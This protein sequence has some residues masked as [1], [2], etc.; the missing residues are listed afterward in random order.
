MFKKSASE[1][2]GTISIL[3][4]LFA[5]LAWALSVFLPPGV[6]WHTAFRPAAL[7]LLEGQSPY[8]VKGYLNAPWA[9]IPL[10]PLALL[11]ET[12]GRAVLVLISLVCF[13]ITAHKI[14]AKIPAIIAL[15]LSP[16]VLHG[17][18]N[19]N[20]D[21]LAVL[22]FVLPPQIG[23]FFVSTKPQIGIGV[24]IY[25]FINIWHRQG[26]REVIRTFTPI[27]IALL[28]SF[29]I[30]GWWPLRFETQLNLWWNA[31][32]WPVSIPVGLALM[33]AAIRKSSLSHAM[34]ASP[35]FSPYVL[36]HSWVGALYAII[37]HVPEFIAAVVGLC[38]MSVK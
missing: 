26:W 5:G 21:W 17:L 37:T 13:T 22:G 19:A 1:Q 36:L 24:A 4:A 34:A 8:V 2:V 16:P 29:A 31:S 18:L 33:V 20:I 6:D 11:P 3:L 15:L 38:I 12:V 14:G 27:S 35:C 28:L 30:F 25:W 9:L 7:A 32:L 23:L 10:L